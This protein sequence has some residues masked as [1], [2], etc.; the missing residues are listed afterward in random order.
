[1]GPPHRRPGP[2]RARVSVSLFRWPRLPVPLPSFNRSP[3]RTVHTHDKTA[4][5]TS[6]PSAKPSSRP[7][8]QVPARTHFP[9]ASFNSPLHTHPSC[10][11]P[12]FKLVGAPS[13]LGLL[14]PNPPPAELVHCPR[15][16]STTAKQSLAVNFASPEVNF[17]A[18]LL[19][20]SPP[21]SM[22]HQLATDDRRY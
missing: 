15:L 9:S 1:V 10:T 22:F 19:L 20:L 5:P 18:G 6:P 11:C 3:A 2:L 17:P 4:T 21:F 16:C 14:R 12:F 8:P 13:S 7:P